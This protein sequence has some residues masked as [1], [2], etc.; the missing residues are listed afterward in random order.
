MVGY[1]QLEPTDIYKTT[2]IQCQEGN[3]MSAQLTADDLA[4]TMTNNNSYLPVITL[5]IMSWMLET[6]AQQATVVTNK[7]ELN[8]SSWSPLTWDQD[9]PLR[10]GFKVTEGI[11]EVNSNLLGKHRP[12]LNSATIS[13]DPQP[14]LDVTHLPS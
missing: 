4:S 7:M 2:N 3:H 9:S 1:S 6:M 5:I 12:A 8:M 10:S 11:T 13:S 14:L